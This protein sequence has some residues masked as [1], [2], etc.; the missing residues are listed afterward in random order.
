[1]GLHDVLAHLLHKGLGPTVRHHTPQPGDELHHYCLAVQIEVLY[2]FLGAV[3]DM[4]FHLAADAVERGVG[5]DRDGSRP[6][7]ACLVHQPAA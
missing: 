3:D 5:A 1:M 7:G 2:G 4:G 6:P